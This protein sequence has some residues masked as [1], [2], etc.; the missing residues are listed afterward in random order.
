[1]KKNQRIAELIVAQ[2]VTPVVNETARPFFD[3]ITRTNLTNNFSD[4]NLTQNFRH[5]WEKVAPYLE[6]IATSQGIRQKAALDVA[7]A[8]I[9]FGPQNTHSPEQTL[10]E[11]INSAYK[12]KGPK[13]QMKN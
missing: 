9:N 5:V 1:M 2:G 10:D 13:L 7:K 8:D 6:K 12:S 4:F 11:R 3:K